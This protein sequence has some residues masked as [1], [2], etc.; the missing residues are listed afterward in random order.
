MQGSKRKFLYDIVLALA[1]IAVGLSAFLVIKLT[2]GE[3]ASVRVQVSGETIG[4]YSLFVDGEYVLNGG[5]NTLVIKDGYAYISH[6]SCPDRLCVKSGKI[7][8][9]GEQ[10]TCLPNNLS[11]EVLGDTGGY[12]ER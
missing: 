11:V 2:R 4:E 6:A 12:I 7:S 5:T 10:I 1:L 9:A 3:G 8:R